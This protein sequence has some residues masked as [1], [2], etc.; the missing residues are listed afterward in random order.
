M[1]G[2]ISTVGRG[3]PDD[4]PGTRKFWEK[5]QMS[6]IVDRD[7]EFHH[8]H[9]QHFALVCPACAVLSHI[10]PVSTPR[11]ADLDRYKP[12]EVGVVFRCDACNSPIFL[13]YLVKNYGDD[14]VELSSNYLE[15]ER[16]AEQ[17][18]FTYLPE[19]SE[20]LFREAL[21]CFSQGAMN[22]FASMCRRTIT[23]VFHDLGETGKMQ[24]FD[25]CN[26]IREMAEI[27]D[28]TFETVRRV[29]FDSEEGRDSIPLITPTQAGALLEFMRDILYQAYVR[30]GKLQQAMM[31][32]RYLTE[33]PS[34]DAPAQEHRS[35]G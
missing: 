9:G 12:K 18:D 21:T 35:A 6:I 24:I 19:D 2:G 11:Y 13:K 7:D 17:F 28:E 25:Q 1:R 22:A 4:F 20:M 26:D 16:T 5:N 33:D 29:L 32:R 10:S 15:I 31:M 30:K 34:E 3:H 8:A 23:L 14:Q 27:D